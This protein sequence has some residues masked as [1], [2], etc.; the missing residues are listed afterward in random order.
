VAALRCRLTSGKGDFWDE[1]QNRFVVAGSLVAYVSDSLRHYLREYP[2]QLSSVVLILR[3]HGLMRL[4]RRMRPNC[5][6]GFEER[7][8]GQLV[9]CRTMAF[10]VLVPPLIRGA[11]EVVPRRLSRT[12]AYEVRAV[13]SEPRPAGPERRADAHLSVSNQVYRIHLEDRRDL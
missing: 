4:A 8:P 11:V 10:P 6:S 7:H 3:S 5:L 12:H 13:P 2:G 9:Q 1:F